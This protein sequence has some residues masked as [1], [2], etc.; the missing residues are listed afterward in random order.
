MW[1]EQKGAGLILHSA[2]QRRLKTDYA[3]CEGD[4]VT[5]S[6]TGP[7]TLSEEATYPEWSD[8]SKATGICFQRSELRLSQ[9]TDGL[10]NTYLI[11]EKYVTRGGYD[12]ANDLGH[13]QSLYSGVDWDINRWVLDPPLPDSDF[14]DTRTFGSAHAGVCHMALCDGSVRSVGYAIDAETHRRLGNRRDGLPVEAP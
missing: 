12:T 13:D 10:S 1:R 6:L 3:C 4:F 7:A 2:V 11:G 14:S 5:D 9:I 8:T